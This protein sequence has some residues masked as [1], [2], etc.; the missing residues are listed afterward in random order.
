MPLAHEI[1]AKQ[2]VVL[3]L[4][5][6]HL[7]WGDACGY[8]WGPSDQRISLPIGNQRDRQ[9]Y[10]GAIDAYTGQLTVIPMEA[11]TTEWTLV[12]VDYLRQ[13]YEGKRLIICWDGASYHR[14][15]AL[16]EYLKA[17]NLGHSREHWP[18][19]CIQFAPYAPEQNP[20]EHVWLQVKEYVRKQWHRCQ[21]HFQSVTDLFEEALDTMTCD[22][23]KLR[24]YLP[25]VQPD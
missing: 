5:K 20:I 13:Q 16:R 7:V 14:S 17:V 8:V 6:C 10:Y 3:Y 1:A 15:I 9:T 25:N 12:F 23:H 2:V 22:F 18:I 24:M 4:D 21:E 11:G 19:T